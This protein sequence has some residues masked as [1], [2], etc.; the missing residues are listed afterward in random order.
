MNPEEKKKLLI[1]LTKAAYRYKKIDG[2][3]RVYLQH[4]NR[5]F[6]GGCMTGRGSKIVFGR[7]KCA[8]SF[9]IEKPALPN[10]I[11]V[12]LE[13]N[14]EA[15]CDKRNDRL[16]SVGAS[17]Y[18]QHLDGFVNVFLNMANRVCGDQQFLESPEASL[19][20]AGAHPI[21]RCEVCKLARDNEHLALQLLPVTRRIVALASREHDS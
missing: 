3:S 20:G 10:K 19:L 2:I 12:A 18:A 11:C 17:P 6:S 1:D 21:T 13:G 4:R 9:L 7:H 15:C 14:Q 8:A 5:K 16:D